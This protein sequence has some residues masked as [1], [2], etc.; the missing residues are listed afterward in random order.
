MTE[1]ALKGLYEIA[2][3]AVEHFYKEAT[4]QNQINRINNYPFG[5]TRRGAKKLMKALKKQAGKKY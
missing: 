4:I 2:G 5:K 1:A 3:L